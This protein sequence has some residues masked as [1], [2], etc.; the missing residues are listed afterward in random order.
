MP[1]HEPG[2][3][4]DPQDTGAEPRADADPRPG[5]DSGYSSH[6]AEVLTRPDAFF[7]AERRGD[8]S[9]ALIDLAAF[10][11]VFF[12]AAVVAR[13]FGYAGFEFRFGS[14]VEGIKATLVM[15]IP[16]AGL[17]FALP[18]QA[19]RSGGTGSADLYLEKIGAAL[20]LPTLL[21]LVA[22]GLD[23]LDVA[24]QSW[25]RGAA[26]VFVYIAVFAASY[27]Y[28]APGRLK[29]AVAATLGFYL[30]YRLLV[31]LF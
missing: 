25:F 12:L 14:L 29:P 6:L 1:E 27:A 3:A 5:T 18:L 31:L 9:S 30:L 15:A 8:R 26:M 7:E 13:T 10:F 11:V 22:I 4:P 21:L 20:L 16:I 24:I 23:I 17:V 2:S 19:A 28:A